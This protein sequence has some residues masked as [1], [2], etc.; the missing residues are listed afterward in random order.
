M[1]D[2]WGNMADTWGKMADTIG[3]E[4]RRADPKL[5]TRL[6]SLIVVAS[7]IQPD[8]FCLPVVWKPDFPP[9]QLSCKRDLLLYFTVI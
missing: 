2:T 4:C 6:M 7:R 5:A 3:E 1:A 8:G 9:D